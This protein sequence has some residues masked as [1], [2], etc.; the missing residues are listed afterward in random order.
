[1]TKEGEEG[2]I[3]E[4][5]ARQRWEEGKGRRRG[6]AWRWLTLSGRYTQ[7]F[8][9]L[10]PQPLPLS[11][12]GDVPWKDD[13]EHVVLGPFKSRGGEAPGVFEDVAFFHKVRWRSGHPA[14]RSVGDLDELA[15]EVQDPPGHRRRA[16]FP[17]QDPRH[18][19]RRPPR[20]P[21]PCSR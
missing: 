15:V 5:S 2:M 21:L 17:L 4:G 9:G 18:H 20:A 12:D 19:P 6:G 16:D 8:W 3:V 14:L 1:M 7:L 10:N 13:L 11:S